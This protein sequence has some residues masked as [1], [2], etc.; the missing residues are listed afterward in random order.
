MRNNGEIMLIMYKYPNKYRRVGEEEKQMKAEYINPFILA[1][2][3]VLKLEINSPVTLGPMSLEQK[4]LMTKEV[5][6]HLGITGHLEGVVFLGLSVQSAC[7]ITSLMLGEQIMEMNETV[8]S[9][10]AELG[11]VISGKASGVL[12][13][14]GYLTDITTPTVVVGID[15]KISTMSLKPILITLTTNVGDLV[16]M[17][18]LRDTRKC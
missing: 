17:V 11:N 6:V 8:H 3:E 2:R 5:K 12:E 4:E 1:A 14:E 9:A 18:A 10:I 15:A 7:E 16:L 13:Q